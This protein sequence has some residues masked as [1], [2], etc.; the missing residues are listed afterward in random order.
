MRKITTKKSSTGRKRKAVTADEIPAN[1]SCGKDPCAEECLCDP[2]QS[3]AAEETAEVPSRSALSADCV[4]AV[5][6]EVLPIE[7]RAFPLGDRGSVGGYAPSGS[8][9][10]AAERD[11]LPILM[12]SY[13]NECSAD[14][15][16]IPNAAGFCR[17]CGCGLNEFSLLR[18]AHPEIYDAVCAIL[19]DEALNSG[20][21]SSIMSVYLKLRLGYGGEEKSEK[22][23]ADSGTLRL[24]FDHDAYADGE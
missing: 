3:E 14:T 11:E 5:E 4:C 1:V 13:L 12:A 9:C 23:V 7:K 19:E 18:D 20:F 15:G 2:P 17:Y 8:L 24:I 10:R 16:R 6:G 22:S 21:S